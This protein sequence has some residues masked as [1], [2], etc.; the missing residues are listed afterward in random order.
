MLVF[1]IRSSRT[2]KTITKTQTFSVTVEIGEQKR[3]E[4]VIKRFKL[5]RMSEPEP[6]LQQGFPESCRSCDL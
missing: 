1:R 3:F 5:Y 2:V 6:S 4:S